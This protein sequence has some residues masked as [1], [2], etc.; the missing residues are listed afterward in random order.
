[1]HHISFHLKGGVITWGKLLEVLEVPKNYQPSTPELLGIK[2]QL[3]KQFDL[4]LD[5]VTVQLNG[6]TIL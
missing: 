2:V 1:M 6:S 5:D 3:A 4:Q